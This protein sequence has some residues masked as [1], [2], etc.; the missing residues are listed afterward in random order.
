MI[1]P[2]Q[3]EK[4]SDFAFGGLPDPNPWK[5]FSGK[6]SGEPSQQNLQPEEKK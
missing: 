5:R 4:E 2:K 1:E 3:E 6:H